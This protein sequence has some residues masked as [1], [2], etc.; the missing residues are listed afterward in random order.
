MLLN[1]NLNAQDLNGVTPE[2]QFNL[3]LFGINLNAQDVSGVTP[4]I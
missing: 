4:L 3:I 1:I 2:G